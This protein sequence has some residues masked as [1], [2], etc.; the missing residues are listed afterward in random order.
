MAVLAAF[1]AGCPS[2]DEVRVGADESFAESGLIE[3]V[4]AAFEVK[5][6]IKTRLEY[7]AEDVD[8]LFAAAETPIAIRSAT[9]A[10]EELIVIGPRENVLGSHGKGNAPTLIEDISRSSHRF[11]QGKK[12]SVEHARLVKL[13]EASGERVAGNFMETELSG[14]E[15]AKRAIETRSFAL[16]RRSSLLAAALQGSLPHR[17]YR[18]GD[19]DLV[20]AMLLLE[21]HPSK[22]RRARKPELFDWLLSEDGRSLVKSFGENRFGVPVFRVGDP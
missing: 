9:W 5:T 16:V 3:Y 21:V 12:G 13:I 4:L 22:T 7:G 10:Q 20:L 15:L 18:E 11:L 2:T 17:I 6:K 8:Y 14:V 19:P 1:V